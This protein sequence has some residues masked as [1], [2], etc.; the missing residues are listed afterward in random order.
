MS[1]IS[2][3]IPLTKWCIF[4]SC[5]FGF[6][7][8]GKRIRTSA[9]VGREDRVITTMTGSRYKLLE[10]D[11]EVVCTETEMLQYMDERIAGYE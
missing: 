3:P 5:V 9:V 6:L 10:V 7:E 11:L 1:N 2:E 8:S 4:G